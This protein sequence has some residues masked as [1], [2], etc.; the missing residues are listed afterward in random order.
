MNFLFAALI[1][2]STS[3][4]LAINYFRCDQSKDCTKAYGGCGRHFAVHRRYKELYEAKAHKSDKTVFCLKPTEIDVKV[5]T[6]GQP[7]C[8][9][10]HCF[11]SIKE[12]EE[13]TMETQ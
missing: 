9:N 10:N 2:F 3:T 12:S 4:G 1:I 8:R 13:E 5:A 7:I 11:L 6:E